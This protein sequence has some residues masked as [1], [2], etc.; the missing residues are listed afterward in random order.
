MY[1]TYQRKG[2]IEARPYELG[3]DLAGVDQSMGEP[4]VG[5]W[6]ARDPGGGRRPWVIKAQWFH[7]HYRLD[8]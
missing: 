7:D 3:E 5:D 8:E 4:G 2:V 1:Q 6:I